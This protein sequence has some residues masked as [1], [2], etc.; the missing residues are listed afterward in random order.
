MYRRQINN[1]LDD[2]IGAADMYKFLYDEFNQL[3]TQKLSDHLAD[4]LGKLYQIEVKIKT[5]PVKPGA[6]E[7]N[8]H[9]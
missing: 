4:A 7:T 1:A 9:T 5:R 8:P 6:S 3:D 2:I